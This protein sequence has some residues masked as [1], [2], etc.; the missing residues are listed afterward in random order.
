MKAYNYSILVSKS[1]FK[2]KA[3]I[4]TRAK[5]TVL[6]NTHFRGIFP[7]NQLRCLCIHYKSEHSTTSVLLSNNGGSQK[8]PYH[9]LT[10]P[11]A[12]TCQDAH[13]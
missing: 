10:E 13:V 6:T 2:R 8:N 3:E 12:P 5:L 1:E 11:H 9:I 7:R 4:F